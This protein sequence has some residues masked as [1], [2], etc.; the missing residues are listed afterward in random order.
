MSFGSYF[1]ILEKPGRGFV[2][3]LRSKTS[4]ILVTSEPFDTESQAAEAIGR[5]QQALGAEGAFERQTTED[6]AFTFVVRD[7]AGTVLAHGQ[8]FRSR[9]L[10]EATVKLTQVTGRQAD[11]SPVA[12]PAPRPRRA[13]FAP[14]RHPMP[15]KAMAAG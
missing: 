11:P 1:E 5:L 4:I 6:G 12:P 7:G 14:E 8:P 10:L 3:R 9:D 15:S 13:R 2:F